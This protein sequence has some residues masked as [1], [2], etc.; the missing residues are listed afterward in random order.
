MVWKVVILGGL[1]GVVDKFDVVFGVLSVDSVY[2]LGIGYFFF[3]F[4]WGCEFCDEFVEMMKKVVV[5]MYVVELMGILVVVFL[6][7]CWFEIIVWSKIFEVVWVGW[8]V[9]KGEVWF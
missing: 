7:M 9:V 1:L 2:V 8:I 5:V 4:Y 3:M 6:W